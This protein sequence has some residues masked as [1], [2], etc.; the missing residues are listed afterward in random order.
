MPS[1]GS[2]SFAKSGRVEYGGDWEDAGSMLTILSCIFLK[3]SSALVSGLPLLVGST[4]W[5]TDES[6]L[7]ISSRS[8]SLSR[9]FFF[10]LEM[11]SPSV[12]SFSFPLA[13]F[14]YSSAI[15]IKINTL[16]FGTLTI[17]DS[18]AVVGARTEASEQ[19]CGVLTCKVHERDRFCR[20]LKKSRRP[21]KKALRVS[22]NFKVDHQDQKNINSNC[23]MQESKN[24]N[25]KSKKVNKAVSKMSKSQKVAAT[26]NSTPETYRE[27]PQNVRL[28]TSESDEESVSE[29]KNG[30]GRLLRRRK[31]RCDPRNDEKEN[32]STSIGHHFDRVIMCVNG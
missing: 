22:R 2:V 16:L 13:T 20:R 28:D 27:S 1:R 17:S 21:V 31:R 18:Q 3:D 10:F 4:I 29:V 11:M 24:E 30:P 26:P 6:T 15:S 23:K 32:F 7:A 19:K 25:N 12:L 14:S 5:I 9:F 8:R